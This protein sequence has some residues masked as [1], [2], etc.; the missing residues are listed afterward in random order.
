MM[1]WAILMTLMMPMVGLAGVVVACAVDVIGVGGVIGSTGSD[2]Q[3][4][5]GGMLYLGDV[6]VNIS[7]PYEINDL[8]RI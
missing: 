5:H 3:R 6:R 2:D 7:A 4:P 8:S 1:M